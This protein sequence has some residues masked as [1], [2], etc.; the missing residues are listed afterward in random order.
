MISH[1]IESQSGLN[2]QIVIKQ[3][4]EINRSELDQIVEL[5]FTNFRFNTQVKITKIGIR[6]YVLN[7]TSM[8]AYH[9]CIVIGYYFLQ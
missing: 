6:Q 8:I 2:F 1:L 9:N 7:T 3:Y 5:L 4:D